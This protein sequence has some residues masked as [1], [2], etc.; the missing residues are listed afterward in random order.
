MQNHLEHTIHRVTHMEQLFDR[1][2]FAAASHP[3]TIRT[4]PCLKEM[5]TALTEYYQGGQWLADYTCDERGDLPP[6]LK[7]GVLSQDALYDLL[8]DIDQLHDD[9]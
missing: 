3:E 7:R 2:R 8:H 6:T 1:L 4:D 9:F 5:L